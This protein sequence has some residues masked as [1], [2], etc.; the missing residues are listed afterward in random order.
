MARPGSGGA[1]F[2][3]QALRRFPDTRVEDVPHV[4]AYPLI[5]QA[6]IV[7]VAGILLVA[8]VV[9]AVSN[10]LSARRRRRRSIQPAVAYRTYPLR[11]PL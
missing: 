11:P 1:Y 4:N 10:V 7:F 6:L 9:S 3:V 2:G 8:I 5:L